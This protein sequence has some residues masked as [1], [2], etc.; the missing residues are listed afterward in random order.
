MNGLPATI[1]SVLRVHGKSHAVGAGSHY[2]CACGAPLPSNSRSAMAN[3]QGA[4]V[5]AA[6]TE[7]GAIE[8]G[9]RIQLS[10]TR[11]TVGL[12]K[13]EESARREKEGAFRSER[14][15]V[16]VRTVGTWREA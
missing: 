14:L 9:T 1:A 6:L 8:W 11:S 12:H 7:G 15:T 16:V 5:A 2:Q 4:M 10:P 13:S 3:H